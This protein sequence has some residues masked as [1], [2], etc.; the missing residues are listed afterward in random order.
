MFVFLVFFL[1]PLTPLVSHAQSTT[2]GWFEIPNTKLRSV[3]PNFDEI[4]GTEGCSAVTADWSSGALD[5]KRNRLI[6]WGGGHNGYYG[7]EIYAVDLNNLSVYRITDPGLPPAPYS[8]TEETPNCVWNSQSRLGCLDAIV[9]GTQPNSRHTYDGIAYMANVDR[10]FAFGGSLACGLGEFGQDTWTFDFTTNKWE[11][12][13]PQGPLPRRGPGTVTAY[14]PNTQK[15]YLYDLKFLHTYDFSSNTYERFEESSVYAP[16]YHMTGVIDPN[17]KKFVMMGNQEAYIIDISPSNVHE[18][19]KLITTGGDTIINS[20][21]P[22]LT[23]DPVLDR[24]V[25]WNG[26][27][28]V[29]LLNLDTNQWTPV[30]APGAPT[31]MA[32]GTYKRW[33]YVPALGAIIVVNSISSNAYL[34]RLGDSIPPASPTP[35]TGLP[36][37]PTSLQ[38]M[39]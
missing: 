3:C 29:Y 25:A 5:V 39:Q 30:S 6:V 26:G 13:I 23:Y 28:T 4:R 24:I 17:R 7:N 38:V 18:T 10:L 37:P 32:N 19:H 21:Y 33:S 16:S 1:L 22:G 34:F 36:S 12:M 14:D 20:A 15:V 9:D 35:T 31:A 2:P 8:C 27:D 11:R